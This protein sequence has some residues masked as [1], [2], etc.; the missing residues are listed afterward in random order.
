MLN[1]DLRNVFNPDLL[2]PSNQCLPRLYFFTHAF[3]LCAK[4]SSSLSETAQAVLTQEAP[5]HTPLSHF[6]GGAPRGGLLQ[7]TRQFH[8]HRAATY[9]SP[10]PALPLGPAR[11]PHPSAGPRAPRPRHPPRLYWPCG[12]TRGPPRYENSLSA[13]ACGTRRERMAPL[14]PSCLPPRL[15]RLLRETR[16]RKSVVARTLRP[17]AR[18]RYAVATFWSHGAGLRAVEKPG[19]DLGGIW[20]PFALGREA[21][22][23]QRSTLSFRKLLPSTPIVFHKKQITRL[24]IF[25]PFL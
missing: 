13:L 1:E 20:F 24:E 2:T 19:P 4:L 8:G 3:S 9:P 7:R 11:G 23:W 18:T 17:D 25:N 10:R 14:P 6:V 12:E 5:P 22:T 15:F 21:R 16:L